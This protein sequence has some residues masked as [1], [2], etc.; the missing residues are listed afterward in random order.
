[1]MHEQPLCFACAGDTL[2]GI[3]SLP[4]DAQPQ[5]QVGV[6]VLVGGPQYR[7]GSHRQFVLLA[8][9]LASAGIP[10]LRFDVRGMGD[11]TGD[12]RDFTELNADI[13][14]AIDAFQQACPSLKG[15]VLWG[16]CDA[17]SVAL[18]YWHECRDVRLQGM[19][20]LNPWVRS[21]VGLARARVRHYYR[22]RLLQAA[23][24]K[25]LLGGK[26]S[27][28]SSLC[29]GLR[30]WRLA[31]RAAAGAEAGTFQSR[32]AGALREFP[33]PLLF[34]L[35]GKDITGQEFADWASGEYA[36]SDWRQRPGWQ[37]RTLVEADHT[38]SR[39]DWQREV[40]VLTADW[41]HSTVIPEV[42]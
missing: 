11:S 19:V 30:N 33:G 1:M 38:F 31:R 21:D 16:L 3:L 14:A 28:W 35:S 6:L 10:V 4:A 22:D 5:P 13:A 26:L 40:E 29:E 41:L 7:A 18:L 17:A 42:R 27:L 9:Y 34:L 2:V 23:F 24:W 36:G 12:P 20:L 25:K 8:R 15:V 37:C 32:M 39:S